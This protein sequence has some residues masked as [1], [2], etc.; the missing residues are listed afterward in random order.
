MFC[1]TKV[2]LKPVLVHLLHNI[3][4]NRLKGGKANF[5]Y[6]YRD[7]ENRILNK[8]V[9]K[10]G[11]QHNEQLLLWLVSYHIL[12]VIESH[13]I[14]DAF[15]FLYKTVSETQLKGINAIDSNLILYE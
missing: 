2:T 9:H 12:E 5:T 1:L 10:Q 6:W 3:A 7:I 13:Q 4:Q 11:F 14:S 8:R 15:E